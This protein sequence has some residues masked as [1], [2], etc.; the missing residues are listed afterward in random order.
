MGSR[1]L[2]F[3]FVVAAFLAMLSDTAQRPRQQSSGRNNAVGPFDS[4]WLAFTCVN[5]TVV[6][7]GATG[8][9]SGQTVVRNC[10]TNKSFG[11]TVDCVGDRHESLC[12]PVSRVCYTAVRE[13]DSRVWQSLK[14]GAQRDSRARSSV[15][16]GMASE[17]EDD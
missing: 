13:C 7:Q 16:E 9:R 14:A 11:K 10:Q 17:F 6:R 4:A 5:K 1:A 2:A 8:V 15:R 3:L 12:A